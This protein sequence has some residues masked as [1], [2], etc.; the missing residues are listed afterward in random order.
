MCDRIGSQ[1]EL[2]REDCLVEYCCGNGLASYELA[3]R[4]GRLI[5]IDFAPRQI[6][7]ARR[8]KPRENI[9]YLLGDATAPV[10]AWVGTS[11]TPNKFL[12]NN[13]LA[14]FT[15]LQLESLVGGILNHLGGGRFSFLLSSIPN[16]GLK[17][18]FY[19]TPDR[20]ARHLANEALAPDT[21]DGLGRWW[22]TEEIE[23]A[24]RKHGLNVRIEN[25]PDALSNYRM[26]ALIVP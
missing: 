11:A 4:V 7:A 1:L 20:L 23:A 19:N 17:E 10:P 18:N 5:G 12:L 25:Q 8:A 24:C 16:F 26:D 6:E 15:P 2:S 13:S 22:R 9:T 3:P 14:Y 21:N